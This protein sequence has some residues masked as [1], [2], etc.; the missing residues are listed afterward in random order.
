MQPGFVVPEQPHDG[1]ILGLAKAHKVLPTQALDFQRAEQ[2]F[3]A[4]IIPSVTTPA[5]EA[6]DVPLLWH[7]PESTNAILVP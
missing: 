4:G 2:R 5:H 1:F 6:Q 3:A 7:V